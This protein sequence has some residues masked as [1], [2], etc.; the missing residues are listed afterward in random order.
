MAGQ[1]VSWVPCEG[2]T[3][4]VDSKDTKTREDVR[5]P[6]KMR[7]LEGSGATVIARSASRISLPWPAGAQFSGG[8]GPPKPRLGLLHGLR[9]LG[10]VLLPGSEWL[11]LLADTCLTEMLCH[12]HLLQR[13]E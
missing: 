9:F 1:K 12:P 11:E 3:V 10:L 13:M 8:G 5:G 2:K 6:D 4:L 7:S